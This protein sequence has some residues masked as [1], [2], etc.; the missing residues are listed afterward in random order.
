MRE[1]AQEV[2]FCEILR[3]DLIS[4]QRILAYWPGIEISAINKYKYLADAEAG[5]V[6][7]YRRQ[8]EAY[9]RPN[10]FSHNAPE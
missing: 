5:D 3:G 7:K 8:L 2:Q 1:R 10:E 6:Q 4:V 9:T